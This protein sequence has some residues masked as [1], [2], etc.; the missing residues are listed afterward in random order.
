M[1]RFFVPINC[2]FKDGIDLLCSE[3]QDV[4]LNTMKAF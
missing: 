1:L 3:S 4:K 2:S